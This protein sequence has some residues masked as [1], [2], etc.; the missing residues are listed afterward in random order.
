MDIYFIRHG[1]TNA[2]AHHRHQMPEEPLNEQ[3]IEQAK[4]VA[5]MVKKLKPTH[6]LSSPYQRAYATAQI[7][8]GAVGIAVE[9]YDELHELRRPVHLYRKLHFGLASFSYMFKWFLLP[10]KHHDDARD[11]ES[12][13]RLRKRIERSAN[14]IA[15]YP[16]DARVVI[17]SH[18]VFINFFV[19]HLCDYDRISLWRA[20]PRFLR[21]IQLRNS[22]ITHI[23]FDANASDT[24]CA[25]ELLSFD[26]RSHLD[27]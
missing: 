27:A 9:C 25:W 23:R 19:Q 11:G 1:Q 6:I 5:A 3:G 22:G 14:I 26:E 10:E 20:W 21:V 18:S 2:N 12:Y 16:N 7:I 17:I 8:S 15:R 13:V 4:R 24:T